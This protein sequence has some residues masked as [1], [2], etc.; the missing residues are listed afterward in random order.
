MLMVLWWRVLLV[1][2]W[3]RV[4]SGLLL[5]PTP[6]L[7]R[8]D[9][10]LRTEHD[11][12]S[13][14]SLNPWGRR[15]VS[16]SDPFPPPVSAR[17]LASVCACCCFRGIMAQGQVGIITRA[18]GHRGRASCSPVLLVSCCGRASSGLLLRPTPPVL[19]LESPLRPLRTVL[20]GTCGAQSFFGQVS[21]G[22]MLRQ[23]HGG[24]AIG[25]SIAP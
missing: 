15:A 21:S 1:S 10:P 5:R 11:V 4:S 16:C 22:L 24:A 19:R 2:C 13:T 25:A 6:P 17:V 12:R 8:L 18:C 7:L 20:V 14:R 9:V 3:G 23:C